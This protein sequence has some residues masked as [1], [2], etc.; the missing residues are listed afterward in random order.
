MWCVHATPS[1]TVLCHPPCPPHTH[2]PASECVQSCWGGAQRTEHR[3]VVRGSPATTQR[4]TRAMCGVARPARDPAGFREMASTRLHGG[5]RRADQPTSNTPHPIH[6][7]RTGLSTRLAC[8]S[9]AVLGWVCVYSVTGCTADSS[10]AESGA[11]W[12][13]WPHFISRR[14]PARRRGTPTTQR[15]GESAGTSTNTS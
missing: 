12:W 2:R 9:G 4:Y 13:H 8:N 15:R 3:E 6:L 11:W 7:D 14:L 5:S 10:R 1:V